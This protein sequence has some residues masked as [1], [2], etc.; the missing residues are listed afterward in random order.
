MVATNDEA[1]ALVGA[2]IDAEREVSKLH[3]YTCGASGSVMIYH[4]QAALSLTREWLSRRASLK[5]DIDE[6]E[7]S[8]AG[9]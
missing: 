1:L 8:V 5:R 7:E 3:V 9:L 4:G 6:M 2:L